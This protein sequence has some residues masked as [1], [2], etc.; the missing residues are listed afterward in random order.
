MRNSYLV[1]CATLIVASGSLCSQ[2]LTFT[3]V[4]VSAGVDY[5]QHRYETPPSSNLQVYLTG[6]AAAAD[7]D[8]DG[9]VDLFVT[10]A[11][12][13]DILFRNNGD[14]TFTDVT[15]QAFDGFDLNAK[16]NGAQWGD[17]DN[18]GDQ[19][20]YVTAIEFTRY[21]LF[22]NDGNG[23]FTEAAVDRNADL[24][25]AD[26]HFGFSAAFG[27]YDL[28][29]YLDLHTTEWRQD[30][31]VK[32]GTP[33]NAKLFRNLGTE[34]PGHF[35][36]VTDMAGVN[37]ESVPYTN[38]NQ[39]NIFEAQSF[40]NRF[41]DLDND[42]YPDLVIASDHTTSR[43]YWNNQ[44]GTFTDGTVD[45]NTGTDH[46]GMGSSTADYDNDGDLD[47]YVTSIY[48]DLPDVPTRN[49]N[50]LYRN[51]GNRVFTD[52]TDAAN[53]RNGEWGWATSFA[54]FDNDGDLDIAQTNGVDFLPPFFNPAVHE[55]FIDDPCRMWL[56][57]GD[58][59]YVE[60]ASTTGFTDTRS[61]KGLLTFDYDNDGDLDVFITNNGEH[62]VLYRNDVANGNN[63]L[64][65]KTIGTESNRDGI[66]AFLTVTPD[67]GSPNDF[68]CREVN[69]GNNMISQDDRTVH[70]GLADDSQIDKLSIRWPSGITQVYFD[71]D[72]NQ[73][74]TITESIQGDVNLDGNV[75]LLDIQPFVDRIL[76]SDFLLQADINGDGLIDLTDVA[77]FVRILS[78]GC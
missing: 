66:C 59:T 47:W 60:S 31:Q 49:G 55:D 19:D 1:I 32:D 54:D 56:N 37:M 57:N 44:D 67:L 25:G 69:G 65:V 8:N 58:G 7:Y 36:D 33:F 26:M 22:I 71:V 62:P 68:L 18:D 39:E 53:V 29:G 50:R 9:F 6:G 74:L 20:L 10:L 5:L 76:S 46:F 27:D 23:H 40:S 48:D 72:C 24:T 35:V 73:L 51:D 75:D 3:D 17:V 4:T 61:G 43:L 45:S 34:N 78:G 11:D 16:T 63:W 12:A 77:P 41:T 2:E 28:D 42:G 21:F 30:F 64:K 38:P 14:G 13:D 15:D 70:F 52:V